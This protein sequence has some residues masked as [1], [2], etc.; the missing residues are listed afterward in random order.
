MEKEQINL[1][2][3]KAC[4]ITQEF[5][6]AGLIAENKVGEHE[7]KMQEVIKNLLFSL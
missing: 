6:N 7:I 3:E 2:C 5:K 4:K 1:V